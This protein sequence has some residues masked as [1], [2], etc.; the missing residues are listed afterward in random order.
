MSRNAKAAKAIAH[1]K[2]TVIFFDLA[3]R[4]SRFMKSIIHISKAI[5]GAIGRIANILPVAESISRGIAVNIRNNL[6]FIFYKQSP[7]YIKFY[8][9]FS[10]V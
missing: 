10:L 6:L 9:R 8:L 5:N 3:V 2:I 1:N 4:L 7:L